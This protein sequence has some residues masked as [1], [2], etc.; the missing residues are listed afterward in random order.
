MGKTKN[1]LAGSQSRQTITIARAPGPAY[2][3]PFPS[4]AAEVNYC[5]AILT[6]AG[7]QP[8]ETAVIAANC[9]EVFA[10]GP[11][12]ALAA[13]DLGAQVAIIDHRTTSLS[14]QQLQQQVAAMEQVAAGRGIHISVLSM[15][16][17]GGEPLVDHPDDQR[18]KNTAPG[19]DPQADRREADIAAFNQALADWNQG[20]ASNETRWSETRWP[21]EQWAAAVFPEIYI[22]QGAAAAVEQLVQ[23]IDQATLASDP[24][25]REAQQQRLAQR[26]AALNDPQTGASRFQRIAIISEP[27][28]DHPMDIGTDLQVV[29]ADQSSFASVYV[30]DN[31]GHTVGL[32]HPAEEV[33]STP[34]KHL[35]RGYFTTSRPYVSKDPEGR[36][37]VV[38]GIVGRFDQRG[39]MTLTAFNSADQP[40]LDRDFNDQG[41]APTNVLSELGLVD[42]S[43]ALAQSGRTFYDTMYD[44]LSGIHLGSGSSHV[45]HTGGDLQQVAEPSG[46]HRD[47]V[48]G[49]QNST[50]I[51][52][53]HQGA[54]TV[55]IGAGLWQDQFK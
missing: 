39:R 32:N 35:T 10:A 19:Q 22:Q 45:T 4:A 55:L 51:G 29:I 30:E 49:H 53:D 47:L 26:A 5:R 40:I 11:S 43:G 41:A 6:H 48:I 2:R 20:L 33:Y 8:G 18:M 38:E 9:Q 25:A 54:K 31:Q 44:E 16:N 23:I 46:P 52:Y 15:D 50:V 36:T 37:Q 21:T 24:A 7:I 42:S 14:N 34:N 28:S 12:F 17:G 1:Q 3:G 27:Q 13:A